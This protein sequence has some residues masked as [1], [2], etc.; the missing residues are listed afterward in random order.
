MSQ[1]PISALPGVAQ[2]ALSPALAQPA[3]AKGST[4]DKLHGAAQQFEAIFVRQMLAEAHKADFGKGL[5]GE[6]SSVSQGLET[7]QQM[8]DGRFADILSAKDAFGFARLIERQLAAR[9]A[10][11]DAASGTAATG[12]GT[13]PTGQARQG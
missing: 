9:N 5:F 13:A 6:D 7:F 12:T 4:A 10:A 11:P 2:Q 3:A 8:Q 1:A